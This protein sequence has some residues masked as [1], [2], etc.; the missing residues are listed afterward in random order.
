MYDLLIRNAILVTPDGEQE[1]NLAIQDGRIIALLPYDTGEGHK[2]IDAHGNYA[3]PG[4][5]D[6]HAHLNE[7]GWVWRED[8]AH[9]TAAA[10]V[11]GTST[12]IDMPLQ[13]NPS[14]VTAEFVE[15]KIALVAPNACVDFCLWGGIV[16]DNFGEIEKMNHAGCV[17]FKSFLSPTSPD[18]ENLSYGQAYE[19]MQIVRKFG[20]RIGFHCEDYSMIKHLE[21]MMKH[22]GRFNGRAFLDSRPVSAEMIATEAVIAMAEETGCAVHICHVSSPDVAQK[23]YEA[24]RRGVDV[25]AETC[26]HYLCMNENDLLERGAICKCAP[27]L[28]TE[29]ERVR[30]WEYVKNGTFSGIGSDHSPCTWEEKH[31]EIL[32]K[33]IETIFDAW[34]GI[35]GIQTVLQSAFS[36]GCGKG[37]VTP[38]QLARVMSEQP[39][40]AFGLWG[41]KGALKEGFDADIV[42]LD[43][44]RAWE[45][46]AEQLYYKNKISGFLGKKGVGMPVMT[47]L[48]GEI[49]AEN[50]SWTGKK[51]FGKV[52]RKGSNS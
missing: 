19:A 2:E 48:R 20:G 37:R 42:L 17:A 46:T 10:A 13:N 8:Y 52:F 38:V 29:N 5:I 1:R 15:Q 39:A 31:S 27:P 45:I 50:G 49:I 23:I 44:N 35:S 21:E 34:G 24:Q 30:L 22:G 12:L 33:K 11:G 26:A 3:F 18:F 9:G 36:E 28:R 6:T 40:K 51:G 41:K 14:T 43:P 47:I 7:P 16:P 4:V 25:T 32:G